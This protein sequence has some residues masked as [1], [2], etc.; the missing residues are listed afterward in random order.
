[1]EAVARL[2]PGHG[3]PAARTVDDGHLQQARFRADETRRRHATP[4]PLGAVRQG[5]G[6]QPGRDGLAAEGRPGPRRVPLRD[7]GRGTGQYP[8]AA[9]QDA[10]HAQRQAP[11][12]SREGT[13]S[14]QGPCGGLRRR[15]GQRVRPLR[16]LGRARQASSSSCSPSRSSRR[17]VARLSPDCRSW[18]ATVTTMWPSWRGRLS[19][20]LDARG[21]VGESDDEPD[22]RLRRGRRLGSR[23]APPPR[24]LDPPAV[25]PRPAPRIARRQVAGMARSYSRDSKGARDGVQYCGRLR[26]V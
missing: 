18:P 24:G 26:R 13:G 1:M 4:H 9:A 8:R 19:Q 10:A 7:G 12:R 11:R 23:H 17:S 15:R 22:E 2:P 5:P 6:V 16:K 25:P 21:L 14:P 20:Q 3:T